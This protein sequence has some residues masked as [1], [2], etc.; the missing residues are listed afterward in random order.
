[1]VLDI[2]PNKMYYIIPLLILLI[3]GN[4]FYILLNININSFENLMDVV[5]PEESIT[6]IAQENDKFYIMI[7]NFSRDDIIIY[8][9]G[10]TTTM[11][12]QDNGSNYVFNFLIH[13]ENNPSN[14]VTAEKLPDNT[15][16]TFNSHYV[17]MTVRFEEAGTY[18]IS[19]TSEQI[20]YPPFTIGL[21]NKNIGLIILN[22]FLAIGALVG[23]IIG[24]VFSYLKIHKHRVKS[25]NDYENSTYRASDYP[26]Y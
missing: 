10:D 22:L 2:K 14:T 7:D 15:S 20:D 12:I 18:V 9:V 13:E 26:N 3:G 17:I 4:L 24:T 25:I 23:T 16:I 1:M 8:T 11:Q 6:I 21:T 5:N 19:T